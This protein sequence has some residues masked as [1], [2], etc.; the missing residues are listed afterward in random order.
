MLATRL[1]TRSAAVVGG[2]FGGGS[3][4]GSTSRSPIATSS[5][6]AA[7]ATVPAAGKRM[8]E[9]WPGVVSISASPSARRSTVPPVSRS[10][11]STTVRV[12]RLA[13]VS[14]STSPR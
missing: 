5:S 7:C 2:E 10:T 13:R 1:P 14:A 4:S 3:L 6:N 11:S 8:S 9:N 12:R